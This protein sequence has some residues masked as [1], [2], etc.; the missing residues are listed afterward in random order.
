M[1]RLPLA[2]AT[3]LVA[4]LFLFNVSDAAACSPRG[5]TAITHAFTAGTCQCTVFR[6]ASIGCNGGVGGG[7]CM[8]GYIG[9]NTVPGN[10]QDC[11]FLCRLQLHSLPELTP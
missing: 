3:G 1:P 8:L 5:F 11:D 9:V 4:L 7:A 10:G 2:I 6:R